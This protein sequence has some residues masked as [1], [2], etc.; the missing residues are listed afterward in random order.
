[1]DV[2]GLSI[3]LLASQLP[4]WERAQESC[5]RDVNWQFLGD[6]AN[7]MSMMK[8][9]LRQLRVLNLN[10]STGFSLNDDIEVEISEVKNISQ[11]MRYAML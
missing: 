1:M 4:R 10:L 7:N 9:P 5:R 8:Q 2:R 11:T 3:S 6:K